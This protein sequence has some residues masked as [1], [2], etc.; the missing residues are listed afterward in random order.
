MNRQRLLIYTLAA[1]LL[2]FSVG[3]AAAWQSFMASNNTAAPTNVLLG[4]SG[5]DKLL[6][7]SG[8]FLLP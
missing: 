7:G 8:G 5:S 1:A 2:I 3:V 4:V 6:D